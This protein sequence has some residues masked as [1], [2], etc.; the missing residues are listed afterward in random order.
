MMLHIIKWPDKERIA[1]S[2]GEIPHVG[3]FIHFSY[4]NKRYKIVA[5]SRNHVLRQVKNGVAIIKKIVQMYS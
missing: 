5:I 4:N 3:D 1:R 2:C